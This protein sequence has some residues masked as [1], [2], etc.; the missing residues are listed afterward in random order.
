MDP[1]DFTGKASSTL[2]LPGVEGLE[3][4]QVVLVGL[5]EAAED[6]S[7]D[8]DVVRRAAGAATR[9]LSKAATVLLV[10][11]ADSDELVRA[12]PGSARPHRT[13]WPA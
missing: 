5:G 7:V 10:L 6:G 11:P 9:A 4:E 3:V 12:G 1:L 8:P 13:T 2:R